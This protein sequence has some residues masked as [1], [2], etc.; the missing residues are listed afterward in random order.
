M[1]NLLLAILL[2]LITLPANKLSA[3]TNDFGKT[4]LLSTL[5]VPLLA[6]FYNT[7]GQIQIQFPRDLK[8]LGV[9]S[10]TNG[11]ELMVTFAGKDIN[12]HDD[13]YTQTVSLEK[14][15]ANARRRIIWESVHRKD[16]NI[17]VTDEIEAEKRAKQ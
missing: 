1:K 13:Y 3:S 15:S 10:T 9:S 14:F 2:A 17:K 8:I 4:V 7:T 5:P 12:Y 11:A 16:L 6:T